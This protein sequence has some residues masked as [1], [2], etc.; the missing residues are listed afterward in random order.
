MWFSGRSSS[1]GKG[2]Y[3]TASEETEVPSVSRAKAP[4][5]IGDKPQ[6]YILPT[7]FKPEV[8]EQHRCM[9]TF[10]YD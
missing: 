1:F 4:V 8:N 6:K 9:T 5:G 2:G 7:I 3:A 10:N